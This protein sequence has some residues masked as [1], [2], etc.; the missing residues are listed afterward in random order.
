MAIRYAID[1]TDTERAA[2]R[3]ILSKN[4]GKRS[5]IIHAYILLKADRSCRWTNA[6]IASADDVSTKKVEQLKKRVVEEG[7]DAALYRKPVTNAHRRTITGEEEAP[8]IA[9]CCRQAPEGRE[10]WT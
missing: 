10:R 7:F 1:L 5:T 8:L 2:L 9:R 4:K 3:E 6:Y